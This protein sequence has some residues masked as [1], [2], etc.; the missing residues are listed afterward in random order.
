M[1]SEAS[2][3]WGWTPG[4]TCALLKSLQHYDGKAAAEV[5]MST[6]CLSAV[7]QLAGSVMIILLVY[8]SSLVK[9]YLQI[10]NVN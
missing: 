3:R 1:K 2:E 9:E 4:A 6:C 5:G 10:T 8:V 7:P